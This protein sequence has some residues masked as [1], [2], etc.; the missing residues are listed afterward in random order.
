MFSVD[1]A[2]NDL[3]SGHGP[4]P[5]DCEPLRFDTKHITTWRFATV[6]VSIV[7]MDVQHQALVV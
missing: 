4:Q 7:S 2:L 6:E 5:C 1:Q 3:R